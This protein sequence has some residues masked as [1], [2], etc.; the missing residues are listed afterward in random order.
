MKF[1]KAKCKVLHTS[2][3]N[4]RNKYRFA[5]EWLE[6]SLEEKDLGCQFMKDST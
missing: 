5:R 1:N 3:C 6:S 4:P 2:M